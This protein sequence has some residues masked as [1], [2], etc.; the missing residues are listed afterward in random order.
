MKL[1]F[2]LIII[3]LIFS[4]CAHFYYM[5]QT[6]NV[7]LFKERNDVQ[8]SAGGSFHWPDM[9]A[10]SIQIAWAAGKNWA[11]AGNYMSSSGETDPVYSSGRGHYADGAIGFFHPINEELIF[12]VFSGYGQSRQ[13]HKYGNMISEGTYNQSRTIDYGSSDLWFRK[14]YLQPAI[15]VS[16]NAVDIALSLRFSGL[17]FYRINNA[18]LTDTVN[19]YEYNSPLYSRVDDIANQ[20]NYYL[21]EPAV[22]IR[23]GWQFVKL[24]FQWANT[25]NIQPKETPSFIKS[26]FVFGFTFSFA[27]RWLKKNDKSRAGN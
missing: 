16:M 6:H 1:S 7:P 26:Q 12:E 8:L 2:V 13:H 18:I 17:S 24:Q 27:E 22:T 21:A 14:Y 10:N 3:L 9:S 19:K 15:G 23:A 20:R 11:L 4:G 25:I 5:P